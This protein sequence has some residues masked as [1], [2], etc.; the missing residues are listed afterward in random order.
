[1]APRDEQGST[2]SAHRA[3]VVHFGTGGGPGRRRFS[4]R[5]E[6]LSSG[7]S[8]HFSSLKGLLAFFAAA[9]DA[10]AG[11]ALW[12]HDQARATAASSLPGRAQC[13]TAARCRSTQPPALVAGA[14]PHRKENRS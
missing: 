10:A 2:L 14:P 8:M 9:L 11:A 6:H 12:R 5:V 3:F 1:M 13:T 4:G 7:E